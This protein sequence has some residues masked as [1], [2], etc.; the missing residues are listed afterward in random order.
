MRITRDTK[1]SEI[2]TLE[3]CFS[4][5]TADALKRAAESVYGE[6]YDLT[7]ERFYNCT[8]GDFSHLGDI[9]DPTALQVYWAK[10]F[11]DFATEFAGT[12]KHLT[13]EQTGDEKQAAQG[14]LRVDWS[15][16]LL[17]FI[18]QYFGLKSFREAEQITIGEILIAKRAQYNQDKYR[19]SLAAIQM[20]KLK[21]K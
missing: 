19:R 14:L 13:I 17:V 11:S 21:Q 9:S 12:L 1:Y 10:R 7:F 20:S 16:G 8:Q 15:E 5:E 6:M 4:A 3:K 18:Q 2:V